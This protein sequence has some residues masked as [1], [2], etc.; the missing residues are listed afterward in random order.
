MSQ[1][2]SGVY[3]VLGTLVLFVSWL[4]FN[5]SAA[6][7]WTLMHV[8]ALAGSNTVIAASFSAFTVMAW[9]TLYNRFEMN[10]AH[11][12]DGL[13]AGCVSITAGALHCEENKCTAL[14]ISHVVTLAFVLYNSGRAFGALLRRLDGGGHVA[15]RRTRIDTKDIVC[16]AERNAPERCRRDRIH[17][18]WLGNQLNLGSKFWCSG[19]IWSLACSYTWRLQRNTLATGAVFMEPWAAAVCGIVGGII[20]THTADAMLRFQLDDV[21]NA[22]A[23]HLTPGMWGAIAVGLFAKGARIQEAYEDSAFEEYV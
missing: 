23:I 13:L 20:Y 8:G 4:A 3:K 21:V 2:N 17:F 5:A 18:D 10:L 1:G 19:Y 14:R 9:K 16:E 22:V 11:S 15:L 12:T 6:Q 7:S